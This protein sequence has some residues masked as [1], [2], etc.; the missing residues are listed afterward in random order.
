MLWY[1]WL[2]YALLWLV[3]VMVF[4]LRVGVYAAFSLFDAKLGIRVCLYGAKLV[5][6][7]VDVPNKETSLNGR[8][9]RFKGKHTRKRRV[10]TLALGRQLVSALDVHLAVNLLVG[11]YDEA[12][13]WLPLAICQLPMPNAV[14]VRAYPATRQICKGYVEGKA[15][16]TLWDLL[17]AFLGARTLH[18]G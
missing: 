5:R 4:P 12:Y 10:P 1:G 15:W 13:R 6:I 7:W 17:R 8:P 16:F 11:T 18:R 9:L 3:V 2:A 14:S